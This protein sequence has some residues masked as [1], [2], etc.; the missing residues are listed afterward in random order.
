PA[1]RWLLERL[2]ESGDVEV[3]GE[4]EARTF[5][6]RHPIPVRDP[7]P[8]R[9]ELLANDPRHQ[10]TIGLL[11][12]AAQTY[13]AVARGETSGTDALFG[14]GE[15]R[16]ALAPGGWLVIGEAQRLLAGQ[17]IWA[18]FVFQL[19]EG[20]TKVETEGELRPTHGF[21]QPETW[22]KALRHAGFAEVSIEPDVFS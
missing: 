13:P 10:P 5:R 22:I 11:D 3:E 8:V 21:L 7:E 20:F 12:L 2:A 18:E 15:A 14:L 4:G 1:L 9:A 17:P 16:E 19:L 6:A